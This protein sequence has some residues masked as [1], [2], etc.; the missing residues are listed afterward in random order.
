MIPGTITLVA[1]MFGLGYGI[2][3]GE[4]VYPLSFLWGLQMFGIALI[5][6]STSAYALDAFRENANEIFIMAMVFKTF[7]FYGMANFT[8]SWLA[9][10]GPV[11]VFNVLG[12]VTVAAV[13]SCG[14]LSLTSS[15]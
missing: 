8:N 2:A 3:A 11:Q 6:I 5:T 10:A 1:S 14:D 13:S 15:A 12:G 9:S 7:F 4:S